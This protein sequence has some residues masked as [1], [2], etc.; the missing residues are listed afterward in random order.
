MRKPRPLARKAIQPKKPAMTVVT[1]SAIGALSQWPM[2]S[3]R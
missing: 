3:L 2:P 1:A